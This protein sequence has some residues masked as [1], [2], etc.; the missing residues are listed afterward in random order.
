MTKTSS[1][2]H[3]NGTTNLILKT[4]DERYS[5]IVTNDDDVTMGGVMMN[6]DTALLLLSTEEDRH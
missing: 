2:Y 6:I 1:S 5:N 3:S 4:I